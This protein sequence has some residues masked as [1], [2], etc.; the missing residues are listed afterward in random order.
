[1]AKS[2]TIEVFGI[3][4]KPG[5]VA[6]ERVTVSQF[7]DGA[8]LTMPLTIINGRR[9]GPRL[10]LQA[11]I[12]GDEVTGTEV[13]V[14]LTS[15][16]SPDQLSGVLVT[17]PIANVPAYLTRARSFTLEER[18]G[19]NMHGIFP[20]A[21]TFLT[22]RIAKKIHDEILVKVEYA[23]DMHTGLTG[24]SCSPF[25]YVCPTDDQDGLLKK[26]EEIALACSTSGVVFY[27]SREDCRKFRSIENYDATFFEIAHRR[28]VA[29]TLWEMGEGGRVTRE[30][31][32]LGVE[33]IRNVMKHLGML[34]GDLVRPKETYKFTKLAVAFA[35]AGGLLQVKARLGSKVR[36]GDLVGEILDPLGKVTP[37][38][39]PTDGLVLRILTHAIIYPGAEVIWVAY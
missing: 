39:A 27:L 31:V 1:M 7:A 20:G 32:D 33:G 23:I 13:A 35:P 29:T 30:F 14:R 16:V 11:G 3:R 37:V 34:E 38:L 12:H 22:D 26:R 4:V 17:A 2:E 24:A 36:K 21:E 15:Q 18:S 19:L 8:P 28:G 9:P 25:S 5:E 6:H 10:Y